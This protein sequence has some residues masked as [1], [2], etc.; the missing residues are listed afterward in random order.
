M[1]CFVWTQLFNQQFK[2]LSRLITLFW[3]SESCFP[4]Q[5]KCK[6]QIIPKP[7]DAAKRANKNKA[8]AGHLVWYET[9]WAESVTQQEGTR[10]FTGGA[11]HS[12]WLIH[13]KQGASLT[14]EAVVWQKSQVSLSIIYTHLLKYGTK[15]QIWGTSLVFSSNATLYFYSNYISE[16]FILLF[17]LL[18]L[19]DSFIYSTN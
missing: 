9:H 5:C 6:V 7:L 10:D 8:T 16:G 4:K 11:T 12:E 19:F 15:V 13:I 14:L 1:I 3:S 18:H 17:T 2:Y